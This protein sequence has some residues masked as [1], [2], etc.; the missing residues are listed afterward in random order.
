M[1][2]KLS[3][4]IERLEKSVEKRIGKRQIQILVLGKLRSS[5]WLVVGINWKRDILTYRVTEIKGA[6]LMF[7]WRILH[8]NK[9]PKNINKIK[10]QSGNNS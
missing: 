8:F 1:F 9:I 3:D 5:L 6:H 7:S 10:E 2:S 4:K